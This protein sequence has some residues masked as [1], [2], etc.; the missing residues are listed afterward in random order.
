[1]I[2]AAIISKVNELSPADRLELIGAVW[3]SF[4]VPPLNISA[5]DRALLDSR[6]SDIEANP[7]DESSWEEAR[8]RLEARL[9]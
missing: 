2:D 4:P 7:G 5:S 6:L 3:E 1:M 8:T 9:R